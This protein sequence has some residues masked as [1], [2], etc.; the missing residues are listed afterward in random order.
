VAG[1]RYTSY[2]TVPFWDE[3]T[4][5][6]G[7]WNHEW[8]KTF[9]KTNAKTGISVY[10]HLPFCEKLCTFCGCNKR[11]T[12]N[13]DVEAPY[14]E[15]LLKEWKCYVNNMPEKPIVREIHLG[16]G[17]PTF[18][19]AD[20]LD[21]LLTQFFATIDR[22]PQFELSYEAHPNVINMEQMQVLYKHGSRR[23]SFGIQ[24]FDPIVQKAINRIQSYETVEKVTNDARAVG[25]TSVNF[26]LIYGLPFQTEKNIIETIDLVNKLRPERI[27]F[28]SYAHVPWMAKSQRGYDDKDLPKDEVKRNLYEQGRMLLEQNGYTEIGMDHFALPCDSLFEAMKSKNL[29]RNFMGYTHS[30]TELMIGLGVSAISDSWG[31]FVQNDKAFESYV[32]TVNTG[33]LPMFRGHQLSEDDQRIR[34]IILNIICHFKH[35]FDADVNIEKYKQ[36]LQEIENDGL[37][38]WDNNTIIVNENARA[39]IRNI[40]MAFDERL[41]N[42]QPTT[43]IFSQTV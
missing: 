5:N 40:C 1:P 36:R 24:D 16:G 28:Y 27:A 2:P 22:H 42:Q 43:R 23:I 30:Y 29:H 8:L 15:T 41:H 26:D 4:I 9:E 31:A 13:H 34:A 19:S 17:T 12:V 14:I 38:S 32:S 37:L 6:A 35:T 39:F 3:T 25:Y 20:N 7:I 18:F 11:I 33:I 10:M 21:K